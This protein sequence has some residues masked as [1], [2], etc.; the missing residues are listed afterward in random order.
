MKI[1]WTQGM[2]EG[3]K[4][5]FINDFNGS[6]PV[7]DRLVEILRQRIDEN[8]A[9]QISMDGFD[10]PNWG[11]KQAAYNSKE[12]TLLEIIDLLL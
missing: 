10:C 3:E 12:K 7:R 9:R 6:K 5:Q 4:A 1:A 11:F 8:R 2:K